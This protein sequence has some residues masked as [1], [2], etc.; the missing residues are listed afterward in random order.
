MELVGPALLFWAQRAVI[1]WRGLLRAGDGSAGFSNSG[2]FPAVRSGGCIELCCQSIIRETLQESDE[3]VVEV[4]IWPISSSSY[5]KLA[6]TITWM[7]QG[8]LGF[9]RLSGS[10]YGDSAR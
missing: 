3:H 8:R 6:G 1:F 10:T 5:G 9:P 4:S 2:G 7:P